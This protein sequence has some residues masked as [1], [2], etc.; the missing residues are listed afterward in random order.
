M[1]PTMEFCFL[2][3]RNDFFHGLFFS[4]LIF[5]CMAVSFHGFFFRG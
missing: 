5:Y 2:A 4:R 3:F 1:V